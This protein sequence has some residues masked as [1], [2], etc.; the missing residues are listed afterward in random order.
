MKTKIVTVGYTMFTNEPNNRKIEK[1]LNKGDK[2]GFT[3]QHRMEEQVGCCFSAMFFARGK[4][5][6]T[7]IKDS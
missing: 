5:T 2:K 3:L 4:T 7:L 6:L 1:V